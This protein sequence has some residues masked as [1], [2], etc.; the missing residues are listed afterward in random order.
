MDIRYDFNEHLDLRIMRKQLNH[1]IGKM[2][3]LKYQVYLKDFR[4][5]IEI[6]QNVDDA[7]STYHE[8]RIT[9]FDMVRKSDLINA[10]YLIVPTTDMR[11]NELTLIKSMYDFKFNS[12]HAHFKSN[13][14][15][16][17][18]DKLCNLIKLVHKINSLKA[19][20]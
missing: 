7:T 19:F 5:E 2:P 16:E 11:F 4:I 9:M 17:T 14:A 18:V 12:P 3:E 10:N 6:I 15:S 1:Y 13:N 8:V 20:L